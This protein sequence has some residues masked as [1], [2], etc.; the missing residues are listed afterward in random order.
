MVPSASKTAS[1]PGCS[2]PAA[3]TR[4]DSSGEITPRTSRARAGTP[5]DARPARARPDRA[6]LRS[7]TCPVTARRPPCCACPRSARPAAPAAAPPPPAA[8]E[9]GAG[10]A[11]GAWRGALPAESGSSV[12]RRVEAHH[13]ALLSRQVALR[14][15]LRELPE[16]EVVSSSAARTRVHA[17]VGL[18]ED[19]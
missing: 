13:R 17:L 10:A 16:H 2:L 9:D 1:A 4:S 8:Q 12:H 19:G 7:A 5:R 14:D 11:G 18:E 3:R 15:R 6:P